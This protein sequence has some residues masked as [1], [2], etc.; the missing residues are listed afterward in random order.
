[1][2]RLTVTV[3]DAVY[4]GIHD[5]SQREKIPLDQLIALALS[6]KLSAMMTED[7]LQKRAARG[8]REKFLAVLAK[9][10]DEE[11]EAHDRLP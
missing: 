1:M 3:P 11:P 4:R 5:L 8:C 2:A 9:A 7:Y 10:R 6:E